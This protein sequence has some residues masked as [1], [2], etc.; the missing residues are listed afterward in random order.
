MT[1]LLDSRQWN[2]KIWNLCALQQQTYIKL[3]I[4]IFLILLKHITAT[5]KSPIYSIV[6][7]K[8][9]VVKDHEIFTVTR[10][11]TT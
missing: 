7:F 10:V 3:N 9:V 11:Q 4:S 5:V 6:L 1:P 2:I 8:R